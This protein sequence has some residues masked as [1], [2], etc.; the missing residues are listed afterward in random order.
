MPDDGSQVD[1]IIINQMN[2]NKKE[3]RSDIANLGKKVDLVMAENA[4]QNRRIDANDRE[5]DDNKESI[6]R[7]FKE[8]K[9]TRTIGKWIAGVL[10]FSMV[11]VVG[12]V[13]GADAV[14]QLVKNVI[15]RVFG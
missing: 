1:N 12:Y 13:G 5:I 6:G 8:I 10:I 4:K 14:V 2:N 3:I 9:F 15:E 7:S 11:S